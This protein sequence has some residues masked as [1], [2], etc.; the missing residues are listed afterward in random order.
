MNKDQKAPQ[1][2]LER[3]FYFPGGA[4][5]SLFAA[6]SGIESPSPFKH[7]KNKKPH[8]LDEIKKESLLA[9]KLRAFYRIDRR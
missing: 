5:T 7:E 4:I 3:Y 6:V 8:P 1:T 2:F 9:K